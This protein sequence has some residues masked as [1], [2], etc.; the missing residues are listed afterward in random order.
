[1]HLFKWMSMYFYLMNDIIII[2]EYLSISGQQ[3]YLDYVLDS[4]L[5]VQTS[6][7]GQQMYSDRYFK[8]QQMYLDRYL[9]VQ[10]SF[11][12]QQMYSDRYLKVQ[13]LMT[14]LWQLSR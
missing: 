11:S 3:K 2:W 6:F 14:S 10:T 5:K 4:Y 13:L 12:G 7:S 1:M 8:V 9:K